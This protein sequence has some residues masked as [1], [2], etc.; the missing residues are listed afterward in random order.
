MAPGGQILFKPR[1]WMHL[2]GKRLTGKYRTSKMFAPLGFK[3]EN[4]PADPELSPA[5]IYELRTIQEFP[6]KNSDKR[7]SGDAARF[8]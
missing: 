8:G 3:S 7:L 2:G 5:I 1:R 6:N 4:D